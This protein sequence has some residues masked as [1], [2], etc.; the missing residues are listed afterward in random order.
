MKAPQSTLAAGSEAVDEWAALRNPQGKADL[1]SG[2]A[3]FPP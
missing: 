3:P 2:G 1:A